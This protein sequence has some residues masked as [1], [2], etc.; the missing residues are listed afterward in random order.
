MSLTAVM[1]TA[2]Q[3]VKAVAS[4]AVE[5]MYATNVVKSIVMLLMLFTSDSALKKS[6]QNCIMISLVL[7]GLQLAWPGASSI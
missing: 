6:D 1:I 2:K 3:R 5:A 7:I 4:T